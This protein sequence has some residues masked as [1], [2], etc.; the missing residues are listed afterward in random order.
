MRY[1][2]HKISF[3][4]L[5][6]L[7][8]IIINNKPLSAEGYTNDKKVFLVVINR[9]S[10][11]DFS[12]MENL[13]GI[14]DDGALALM[15]TRGYN[16]Y[17]DSDSYMTINA[18]IRSIGSYSLSKF[19]KNINI[20]GSTNKIGQDVN[21]EIISNLYFNDLI[22]LNKKNNNSP[23]VGALGDNLHRGGHKTAVFGN[24]D[25]ADYF[26]RTN[27]FIATDSNG[28]VDYGNVD[29]ILI[30]D[31][32]NVFTYKT[33]YEK[34][35]DES[36][37]ALNN[38]SFIV[39]E[40]GDLN[41]LYSYRNQTSKDEY[42]ESRNNIL[43]EIDNFLGKLHKKLDKNNNRLII[44]SPNMTDEN[45][46]N[47]KLSPLIIWGE[48]INRGILTSPTTRRY[49]VVTNL[50][51]AP[52]ITDYLDSPSD[53]FLGQKITY[54]KSDDNFD[55][56]V[57]LKNKINITSRIRPVV[58]KGFSSLVFIV[59]SIYIIILIT[60]KHNS[61]FDKISLN[62]LYLIMLVPYTFLVVS[63][64]N[65][66]GLYDFIFYC[67]I[68]LFFTTIFLKNKKR[69]SK[70]ILFISGLYIITILGDIFFGGNLIKHSIISYD[71]IIGARYFGIGNEL[72]G[73]LIG[74]LGVFIG[75]YLKSYKRYLHV[76]V[77]L[78]LTIIVV[79][80][81]NLGA[82]LGG[83][84]SI[85]FLLLSFIISVL[86]INV[87]KTIV[88]VSII[89]IVIF[90]ISIID[91]FFSNSPSHLGIT[92]INFYKL[93]PIYLKDIFFRKV[94]MNIRLITMSI[95]GKTLIFTLMSLG[96]LILMKKDQVT[97][98]IK[99]NSNIGFGL[100]T[101]L[102]GSFFG[103]LFNDS[104]VLLSAFA[105]I[106]I[107]TMLIYAILSYNKKRQF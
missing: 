14:V 79:F 95:W 16:G 100:F 102:I 94:T 86:R 82:N 84:I 39:I 55:K 107:L 56:V 49:G 85:F 32:D 1:K 105:N 15:N 52:T 88:L 67:F 74:S 28:K 26:I 72:L 99:N 37:K 2:K 34:L 98:Y 87:K 5:I 9:L 91:I 38:A 51:I 41:R 57:K 40:T 12:Y 35:L 93:G 7:L 33:N 10:F 6:I 54:K 19:S 81:P 96:L 47:S 8:L 4:A 46:E 65:Y 106:Y 11:K 44:L 92:I 25:T 30:K 80:H 48:G 53:Y 29:D 59:I 18:S 64:F 66:N 63:K 101:G 68:I 27:C 31:T 24:S 3:Y 21:R 75:L 76:L 90:F 89:S 43:E 22:N 36:V 17:D 73:I 104:G 42:I 60:I 70:E 71:P 58:L 97:S 77:I 103:F 78:L 23:Y 69:G 62:P 45:I 20:L 13:K 61:T 83:T 50:D